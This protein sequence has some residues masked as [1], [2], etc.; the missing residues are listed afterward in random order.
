MSKFTDAL[1]VAIEPLRFLIDKN[2]RRI[3]ELESTPTPAPISVQS[4]MAQSDPKAPDYIKNRIVYDD[5]KRTLIFEGD[6][7]TYRYA[8]SSY[9]SDDLDFVLKEDALYEVEFGDNLY[10]KRC[11][12]LSDNYIQVLLLG[13]PF[14]ELRHNVNRTD[15]SVLGDYMSEPIHLK[16]SLVDESVGYKT[17]PKHLVP[18]YNLASNL[19]AGIAKVSEVQHGINMDYVL[20]IIMESTEGIIYA[21][22][23]LPWWAEDKQVVRWDQNAPGWVPDDGGWFKATNG[24]YYKLTFEKTTP[25]FKN[26]N[27]STIWRAGT[28]MPEATSSDSGKIPMV[29]SDGSWGLA[30]ALVIN[31]STAGSTKK[32]RLTVD[33]DGLITA[34]E[35]T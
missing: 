18:E 16:V 26:E 21:V 29:Q 32:F 6:V 34:Q 2:S 5:R 3:D 22:N 33:D 30:E 25:V 31:S 1:R 24:E 17:L 7:K 9:Q 11:T 15:S 28:F 19:T 20:P 4:D 13:S 12:R 35:I 8:G 14:H 23:P 27:D 10:I